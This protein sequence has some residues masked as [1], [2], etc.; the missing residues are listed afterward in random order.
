MFRKGRVFKRGNSW[1][2]DFNN[3]TRRIM[4]SFGKN[5]RL[6]EIALGKILAEIAEGKYLDVKKNEKIKFKDF[7]NLYLEL[8]AK[9]IS[10]LGIVTQILSS[11]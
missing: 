5:K 8:Y 7:A 1:Y 3:G 6:A 10:A 9:P 2:I 4:K 11:C